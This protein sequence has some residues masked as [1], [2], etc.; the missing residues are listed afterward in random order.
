MEVTGLQTALSDQSAP[1][2]HLVSV[3]GRA[4]SGGGQSR[5]K[6]GCCTKGQAGLA[7]CALAAL[8]CFLVCLNTA[9]ISPKPRPSKK[10]SSFQEYEVTVWTHRLKGM[11]E[12]SLR[13]LHL[14]GPL[15]PE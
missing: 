9:A 1:L 4:Q 8:L 2:I 5:R 7:H 10:P 3:D 11:C 14:G 13:S 6:E 15:F 12:W